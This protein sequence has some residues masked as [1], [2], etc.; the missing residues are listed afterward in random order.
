MNECSKNQTCCYSTRSRVKKIKITNRR[1]HL[2]PS[3]FFVFYAVYLF[4]IIALLSFI[5]ILLLYCWLGK[6]VLLYYNKFFPSSFYFIC[7]VI[8]IWIDLFVNFQ[9]VLHIF[10]HTNTSHTQ[11]NI[12]LNKNKNTIQSNQTQINKTRTC[13]HFPHNFL[14]IKNQKEENYFSLITSVLI[15]L[16]SIFF[17]QISKSFA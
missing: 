11:Q 8:F 6:G 3:S 12:D 16:H 4:I 9:T 2:C 7:C 10:I 15:L 17:V 14:P 1:N 13:S 5:Y